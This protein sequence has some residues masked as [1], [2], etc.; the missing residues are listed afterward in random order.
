MS[1]PFLGGRRWRLSC[2]GVEFA[3]HSKE[4]PKKISFGSRLRSVEE[5]SASIMPPRRLIVPEMPSLLEGS[6]SSEMASVIV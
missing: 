5:F 4:R 2:L 3:E 1:Q 6:L